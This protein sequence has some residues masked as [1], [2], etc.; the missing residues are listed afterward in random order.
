[1]EDQNQTQ[2]TSDQTP[3]VGATE[4]SSSI[5]AP[6]APEAASTPSAK[7]LTIP[8]NAMA[9]IKREERERGKKAVIAELDAQAKKAGY[10]TWEDMMKAATTMKKA[11]PKVNVQRPAAPQAQQAQPQQ[12]GA[13]NIER[14]ARRAEK[15]RERALEEVRRL[16]RA[17]AT[18][19]KRRKDAERRLQAMEAE[20]TLRTAAV[21]AGVQDVD[22]ALELLRRKINGKTADDLKTFSEDEFFVKELRSSH[23]YLYGVTDVPANTAASVAAKD[24]PKPPAPAGKPTQMP[25]PSSNGTNGGSAVD[26]RKLSPQEYTDLLQRY[27]IR[28]PTLG[29]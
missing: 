25:A 23:P 8:S 9:K 5:S 28:N 12:T 2:Q 17:R 16:N 1:M 6:Q 7:V 11:T 22:Y 4:A 10:S 19:E 15:E 24:A 26:A 27:G 13:P 20:M 21:R 14:N 3:N 29:V 18:E